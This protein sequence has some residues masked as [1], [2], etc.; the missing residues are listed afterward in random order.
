MTVAANYADVLDQLRDAGL[1][2]PDLIVGKLQRCKVEGDRERR[3]WYS[4][5]DVV[6]SGGA[7]LLFGS[8]GV[9]RGA[10]NGVRK[11]ELRK[12]EL[13]PEQRSAMKARARE[14]RARIERERAA[15]AKRA[16]NRARAVWLR[17]SPTGESEYLAR[18]GVAA[19][20]VRF[21]PS[22]A[23]VI[24]LL[25]TLANVHGLQVVRTRKAAK[26]AHRPEKEFFPAG[27]ATKGHFFLIGTPAP[28]GVL[29]VAEGYATA[30]SLHE[31]TLLP[32]AVAF[33]A[34]NIAPVAVALRKRYKSR[35]LICADDDAFTEG[36][37]G[38]T[39]GSAAAAEVGGA[40]TRPAF[41]DE[42]ARR[43]AF[44]KRHLKFTDYNDLHA[45]DG[46]H[47]VR[48]QIERK[49]A[50]LDWKP[51]QAAKTAQDAALK[52]IHTPDELLR[53]YTLVYGMKG[54]HF[55]SEERCLI[56]DSDVRN[57][58]VHKEVW[59]AFCESPER[60]IVRAD[61][62]GFDPGETDPMI[63]CNLWAGWPNKPERGEC[64]KLL[65]LLQ[66]MCGGDRSERGLYRWVL[67]WIA[68]PIQHPGAKMK[69]ALVLHGP[70]GTGKNLFFEAI[71]AI[72]GRYAGII[73]QHALEDKFNDWASRKLFLIADEVVA[74]SDLFHVKNRLKSFI[75]GQWIRINPKG[76]PAYEEKN[77]VNIVFL[78]NESMPVALDEDDRRHAVIF[79]PDKREP[80]FYRAVAEEIAAGG[81]AALHDYLLGL[82]LGDFDE[83]TPPPKTEAKA[84]LIDD[85]LDTITRF[86]YALRDGDVGTVPFIAAL[87]DELY[88]VYKCWCARCGLRPASQPKML[89]QLKRKH[90]VPSARKYYQLQGD[91]S[92]S[93]RSF[94]M[95]A[96]APVGESESEW[97][98][99][100]VVA[101]ERATADYT[102]AAA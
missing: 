36:N 95:L 47:V 25:D 29:L 45:I 67:N 30:A 37:P 3:G 50:A 99:R 61:A 52:P 93:A 21:S 62:V 35:I 42:A 74:R 40:W 77:H 31:A 90:R 4:L 70:Q 53:R 9:W 102:E 76:M 6:T 24:P 5:H 89:G 2:V 58:C 32:V 98:G 27:L 83:A 22:G 75:T 82:D 56:A 78:S 15:E 100:C 16:T 101:F 34:N 26:N 66:H 46:L 28:M 20:G 59:R 94:V 55:D 84:D 38:V 48:D 68:C 18:K 7:T 23:L 73:D 12:T 91:L 80:E 65:E 88:K 49:L 43:E 33:Y 85:G 8:F 97:L 11:I 63:T 39:Y 44:E 1:I 72:Y 81:V 51:V 86:Y 87:S 41:A 17:C 14:D 60:R 96:Q 19:H 57:I 69:T 71:M 79:T 92:R 10:D 64:S 54:A 13:T